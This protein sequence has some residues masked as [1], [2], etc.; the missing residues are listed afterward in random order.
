MSIAPIFVTAKNLETGQM[1]LME[2]DP[3]MKMNE[4]LVHAITCMTCQGTM[5]SEKSQ[6]QKVTY[7]MISFI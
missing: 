5:L 1:P 3:A 4:L 2:Y 6:S 7:S